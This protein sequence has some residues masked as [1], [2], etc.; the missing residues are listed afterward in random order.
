MDCTRIYCIHDHAVTFEFAEIISEAINIH[1]IALKNYID[2]HPFKGFIESVP[3]YS[4]LTVYFSDT[5]NKDEVVDI[6]QLYNK[7][8]KTHNPQA[9]TDNSELS[10]STKIIP[11][12]YDLGEDLSSVA[13]QLNI[14][15]EKIIA[16][17]CNQTYR[18]YTIGFTPGFPYMGTLP[19]GLHLPR[20]Q[21][22][23]LHIA[24][25][26]VAIAGNQTGIYPTASPGGWHIIGR[27]PIKMFDKKREPSCFLQPGDVV[28]FNSISTKEFNQYK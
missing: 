24:P 23:A 5:I 27:T 18:V 21:T 1:V 13:K 9:T 22:P 2:V 26:S 19:A 20:K 16:L 6:I 14:T 10:S 15:K 11:V 4:S 12:C 25:G 17:H 3:A 8:L 7:Q 28:Q